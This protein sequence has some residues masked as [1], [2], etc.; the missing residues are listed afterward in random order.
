[1]DLAGDGGAGVQVLIAG[2]SATSFT[3]VGAKNPSN[4]QYQYFLVVAVVPQFMVHN[5]EL[6]VE[7]V[8]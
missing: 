3:G 6:R 2:P 8:D 1:M 5:Q 7:Q 4:N